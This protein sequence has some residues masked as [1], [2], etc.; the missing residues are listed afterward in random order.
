MWK[1]KFKKNKDKF[2]MSKLDT[3]NFEY[4]KVQKSNYDSPEPLLMHPLLSG[5]FKFIKIDTGRKFYLFK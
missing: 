3:K 4:F 1:N 5:D 2:K